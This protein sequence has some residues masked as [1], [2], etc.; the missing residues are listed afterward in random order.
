METIEIILLF[1]AI[2]ALLWI[3]FF[4]EE[5]GFY[6]K[7]PPLTYDAD[8]CGRLCDNTGGCNSYYYDPVT[9]QCWLNSYYRY[10]DLM[11][12]YMNNTYFWTPARYR[13]GKY[14]VDS[15][16]NYRPRALQ[17]RTQ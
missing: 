4:R 7:S 2:I 3:V 12:P 5:E 15:D 1:I 10:G 13:W 11:Y 6:F 8:A 14:W 9:R 17:V 16:G